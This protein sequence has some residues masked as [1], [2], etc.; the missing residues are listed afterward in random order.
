MS[1]P[2]SHLFS[3][4]EDSAFFLAAASFTAKVTT[5]SPRLVLRAREY[6]EFDLERAF[7]IV[8]DVAAI[9]G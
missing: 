4:H 5:F 9:I 7:R 6:T 8:K 2:E 1:R 3:W